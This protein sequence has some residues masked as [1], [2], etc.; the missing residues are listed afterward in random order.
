MQG[1]CCTGDAKVAG[2]RKEDEIVTWTVTRNFNIELQSFHPESASANVSSVV[3][4]QHTVAESA[5]I[6]AL[7][8]A[9]FYV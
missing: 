6:H 9:P 2:Q 5:T 8:F 1:V 4:F 3:T 7:G